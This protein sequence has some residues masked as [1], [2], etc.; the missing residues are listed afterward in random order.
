MSEATRLIEATTDAAVA[1]ASGEVWRRRY[2]EIKVKV[3]EAKLGYWEA[4]ASQ[5]LHLEVSA[6]D[7]PPGWDERWYHDPSRFQLHE[8]VLARHLALWSEEY[9][10]SA[11]HWQ[12]ENGAW[13]RSRGLHVSHGVSGT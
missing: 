2:W 13:M 5:V 12:C 7:S 11:Q 8:A 3:E 6:P 1:R 10:P 4:K 9:G